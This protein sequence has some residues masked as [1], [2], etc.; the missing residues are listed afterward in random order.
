MTDRKPL[1]L[2]KRSAPSAA[3]VAQAGLVEIL[4]DSVPPMIVRPRFD[5]LMLTQWANDNGAL[6]HDL[7]ARAGAVL[8]RGFSDACP[9]AMTAALRILGEGRGPE[10][11]VNRSTP[12][13]SVGENIYTATEYPADRIIPP[14]NEMSYTG[15]WPLFLGL[16]C[17]TPALAGGETPIYDSRRVLA[18]IPRE[19]RYAFERHGVLYIRTLSA[20]ID[21]SW[22]DVFQTEDRGDVEAYCKQHGIGCEWLDADTL[23]IRECHPAVRE[24]PKSGEAVWFNQAHLFHHLAIGYEAA[25]ILSRAVGSDRLPRDARFGNGAVIPAEMIEAVNAAYAANKVSFPW[26]TGDLLLLDNMRIRPR[27]RGLFRSAQGA[28]RHDCL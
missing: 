6:L 10:P 5:G 26:Q 20:G 2:K 19:V 16:M 21:L 22:Q 18:A 9:A 8:L 15:R 27:P 17:V 7:V 23:R 13:H 3:I 28:R 12:R 1:P 11:Y 24:H 4:Q 25:E 14:H